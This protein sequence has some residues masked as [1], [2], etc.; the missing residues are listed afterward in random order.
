MQT[1]SYPPAIAKLIE[2]RPRMPL[3]AGT[4]DPSVSEQLDS[5]MIERL[6]GKEVIHDRTAARLCLA[7]LWLLYDHLDECH[8]IAQS[9]ETSDGSYWHAIMHR[10]EGDFSNSKYW[11]HRVGDHPIFPALLE[12][13]T[14][15]VGGVGVLPLFLET[16]WDPFAFVDLVGRTFRGQSNSE[17]LCRDIQ[18]TEWQ[19][20]FDHCYRKAIESR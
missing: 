13:T 1:L 5:A 7:G 6:F 12:E 20:L 8:S 11:Y 19:L 4:P 15:L 17:K 10:R 14:R 2:Q 18:Q 3:V 9:I 16:H